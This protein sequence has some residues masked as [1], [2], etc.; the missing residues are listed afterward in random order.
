MNSILEFLLDLVY[1]WDNI[2]SY[3][4][5]ILDEKPEDDILDIIE[6]SLPDPEEFLMEVCLHP[7]AIVDADTGRIALEDKRMDTAALVMID[8]VINYA[9]I[10]FL[11]IRFIK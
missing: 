2:P 8:A 11:P 1:D 3:E 5:L 6:D 4:H 9:P 10:K 7:D